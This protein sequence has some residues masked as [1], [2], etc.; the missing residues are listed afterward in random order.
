MFGIQVLGPNSRAWLEENVQTEGWQWL[1]DILWGFWDTMQ[2]V[3]DA[4]EEEGIDDFEV[5]AG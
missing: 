1:G 3:V 4:M 5:C 2:A